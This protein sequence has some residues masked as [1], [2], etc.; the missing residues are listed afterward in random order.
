[1]F[2][3]LREFIHRIGRSLF[4][5][6]ASIGPSREKKMQ[7]TQEQIESVMTAVQ[8]IVDTAVQAAQPQSP[9]QVPAPE[10]PYTQVQLDEAVATAVANAVKN[11]K[12]ELQAKWQAVDST[13]D[14]AVAALFQ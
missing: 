5:G 6:S 2:P 7:F 4:G 10:T 1:M 8:G 3:K 11:T 13:N 12:A 14:A 9:V